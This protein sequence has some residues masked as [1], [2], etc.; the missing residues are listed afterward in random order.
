MIINKINYKNYFNCS[1]IAFAKFYKRLRIIKDISI[2]NDSAIRIKSIVN[3][4]SR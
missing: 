4:T 2:A 3:K 1:K